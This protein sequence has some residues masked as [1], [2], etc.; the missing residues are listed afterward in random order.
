[1]RSA[2]SPTGAQ[3]NENLERQTEQ[4]RCADPASP[5]KDSSAFVLGV[6]SRIEG[7]SAS[8]LAR[9][10]PCTPSRPALTDQGGRKREDATMGLPSPAF[11]NR[12]QRRF[13]ENARE[14]IQ[15]CGPAGK[16]LERTSEERRGQADPSEGVDP[17]GGVGPA[18]WGGGA[19][20]LP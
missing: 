8:G 16:R 10:G 7:E 3:G 5:Y 6:S 4:Q 17:G 9:W 19:R 12:E 15:S 11:N 14:A 20:R 1:M 2:R 18:P 13:E